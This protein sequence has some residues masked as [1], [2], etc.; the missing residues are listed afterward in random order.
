VCDARRCNLEVLVLDESYGPN[1]IVRALHV[2]HRRVRLNRGCRRASIERD[3]TVVSLGR[4][5]T[6]K[7]LDRI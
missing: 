6:M 7:S 2:C 4:V 5:S 1:V 3:C